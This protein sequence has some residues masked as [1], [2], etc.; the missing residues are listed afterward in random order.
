M[1]IGPQSC[2]T[3]PTSRHD[4]MV[5]AQADARRGARRLS[6]N[7]SDAAHDSDVQDVAKQDRKPEFSTGHHH[8]T[9]AG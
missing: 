1:A 6:G 7:E 9:R 5:N 3:E 2:G 8:L 4:V